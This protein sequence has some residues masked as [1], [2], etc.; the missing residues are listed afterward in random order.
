MKNMK[1]IPSFKINHEYK[2]VNTAEITFDGYEYIN[3]LE[4]LCNKHM[5]CLKITTSRGN[6]FTIG[7][8]KNQAKCKKLIYDIR[9]N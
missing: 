7:S 6:V 5:E 2:H 9:N 8:D 3:D 1:T 4:G